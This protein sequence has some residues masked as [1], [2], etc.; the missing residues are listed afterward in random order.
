MTKE[1][2]K[3]LS[4]ERVLHLTLKK[5]WFDMILYGYKTEEYREIKPYWSKRFK[6]FLIEKPFDY[7]LFKNGYSKMCPEIAV[8]LKGIKFGNSKI[9]WSGIIEK[10]YVLKLGQ[11]IYSKN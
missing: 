6:D 10:C 5:K 7:I 11:I 3:L 2:E 8:E 9:K 1:L 4:K